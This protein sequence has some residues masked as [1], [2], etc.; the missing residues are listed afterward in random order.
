MTASN[1]PRCQF[2]P[3]I[4]AQ[5][6]ECLYR[7]HCVC[8]VMG[9]AGPREV[10]GLLQNSTAAADQPEVNARH[11]AYVTEAAAAMEPLSRDITSQMDALRARAQLRQ[12]AMDEATASARGLLEQAQV[13]VDALAAEVAE[14]TEKERE[15]TKLVR[16]PRLR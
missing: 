2:C 12:R 1:H 9:D 7:T 15:D 8:A 4:V 16:C 5:P 6:Q 10:C 14:Q 11:E 13:E 3:Q